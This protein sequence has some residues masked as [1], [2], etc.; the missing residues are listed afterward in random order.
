MCLIFL[1]A[2]IRFDT[3]YKV[4]YNGVIQTYIKWVLLSQLILQET[5]QD[6]CFP[7]MQCQVLPL[8]DKYQQ[9]R[10]RNHLLT[11]NCSWNLRE[12][13]DKLL[14]EMSSAQPFAEP[15]MRTAHRAN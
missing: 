9:Q 13:E 3:D 12:K 8:D 2:C 11:S 14:W 5:V 1:Y 7:S 10:L 6:L 4:E 15:S